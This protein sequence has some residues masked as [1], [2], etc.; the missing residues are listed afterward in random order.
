M[1][2]S[3]AKVSLKVQFN[4]DYLGII[5]VGQ[6]G[7]IK[8]FYHNEHRHEDMIGVAWNLRSPA[9]YVPAGVL[10]IVPNMRDSQW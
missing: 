9:V 5:P 7:V 6:R 3:E 10:D 8:D 4:Q 1:L 2:L